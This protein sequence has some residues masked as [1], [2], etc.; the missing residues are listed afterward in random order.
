MDALYSETASITVMEI[1]AIGVDLW[2]AGPATVGDVRFWSSLVSLTTGLV[3]AY[4]VNVLLVRWGVK[5][6]MMDPREYRSAEA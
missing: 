3:A 4:P 1:V 6:G 2:L 5:E